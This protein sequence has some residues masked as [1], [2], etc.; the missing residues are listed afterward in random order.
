M[1][2]AKDKAK[3]KVKVKFEHG[4]HI[5][6]EKAGHHRIPSINSEDGGLEDV[7]TSSVTDSTIIGEPLHK[8]PSSHG[9]GS[10][11]NSTSNIKLEPRVLHGWTLTSEV[12][13]R[14]VCKTIRETA[15]L[16]TNL[17][18]IVSLEVHADLEQQ[19]T[20]VEIMKEEW[21][22]LLVDRAHESC[23][24]EERLPKLS[25]L[26]NKVS[27]SSY[28]YREA[29]FQPFT[30]LL[31]I[32]VKV[33]K[34]TT[35]PGTLEPTSSSASLTPSSSS[36]ASTLAPAK[37]DHG[38][39]ASGSEDERGG[40]SKK[41]KTKICDSLSQLGIYTHSAHFSSFTQEEALQPPHVFSISENQI[42]ELHNTHQME[43][44][45][46]NRKYFMRA[47][48]AGRR[49][50]SSNPDPSMFWRRGVQ[51]VAL[52]WQSWDEGTMINEAMFAGENGWV[53]KPAAYLGQDNT[54]EPVPA[55]RRETLNLTITILAGQHIPLPPHHDSQAFYPLVK[56]ELHVDKPEGP[57]IERGGRT[58]EGK[59]K[60]STKNRKTENPDW[61]ADGAVMSFVDVQNVIPELCF[62]R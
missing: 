28:F 44:F 20:M 62:L 40:K 6:A 59:Y 4:F 8:S 54:S 37:F 47:Y 55:I 16:T 13:F 45:A 30:Y 36:S 27:L 25:D 14:D 9:H 3:E 19:E 24:P 52:N 31:Q 23:K 49:I 33:K 5:I 7:E 50:D 11:H 56:C 2:E 34:A 48:P 22:G 12:P 41:K 42:L 17:P 61:G 32:L 35:T 53:L 60:L 58:K 26:L 21:K 29:F 15:F 18:I 10:R 57:L 43:L 39:S 38:D 46:H 51:M 1:K